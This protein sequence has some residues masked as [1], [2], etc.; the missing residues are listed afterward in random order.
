M[1]MAPKWR[2][3]PMLYEAK[4]QCP[5]TWADL[6]SK[7]SLSFRLCK[8]KNSWKILGPSQQKYLVLSCKCRISNFLP[9]AP[10]VSSRSISAWM[11]AEFSRHRK[12]SHGRVWSNSCRI[13]R[14]T[15]YK[16]QE[17]W[18]FVYVLSCL[19]PFPHKNV[20]KHKKTIW[21]LLTGKGMN[22][23]ASNK[24]AA[25][26]YIFMLF[27]LQITTGFLNSTCC[28]ECFPVD[29][30]PLVGPKRWLSDLLLGT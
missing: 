4:L 15:P 13:C 11:G 3:Q 27:W 5:S 30:P 12:R 21:H 29:P 14:P 2:L 25:F 1:Q 23:L 8:K 28:K 18:F 26:C 22:A 6:D 10:P 16:H 19:C 9:P 24:N 17:G 7:C 20:R